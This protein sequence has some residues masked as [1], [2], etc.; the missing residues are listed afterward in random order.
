[1]EIEG[2][3]LDTLKTRTL[4]GKLMNLKF[5]RKKQEQVL[6]QTLES[7]RLARLAEQSRWANAAGDDGIVVIEDDR[8]DVDTQIWGRRSFLNFNPVHERGP[9]A[10]APVPETAA[11]TPEGA[12][13]DDDSDEPP[14]GAEGAEEDPM[15]EETLSGGGKGKGRGKGKGK[16][17]GKGFGK[18]GGKGKGFGKGKGGKGPLKRLRDAVD[19]D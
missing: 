6:R 16:G 9:S 7:E 8:F 17:K 5:M 11:P 13:A 14:R 18:G 12:P 2:E 3:M 4:S 10:V 19:E 15:E 1:M